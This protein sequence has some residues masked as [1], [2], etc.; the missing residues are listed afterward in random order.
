MTPLIACACVPASPSNLEIECEAVPLMLPK[1]LAL[2]GKGL[3]GGMLSH[4][5]TKAAAQALIDE[6]EAKW[7]AEQ[8]A[9]Q[10]AEDA[11]EAAALGLAAPMADAVV[12]SA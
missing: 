9:L 11:A 8:E 3:F 6:V 2:S 5:S 1:D 10:A 7:N 4:P 12:G